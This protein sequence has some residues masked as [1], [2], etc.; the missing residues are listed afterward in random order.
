MLGSRVVGVNLLASQAGQVAS[1][2]ATSHRNLCSMLTFCPLPPP[3][4]TLHSPDLALYFLQLCPSPLDSCLAPPALL[5]TTQIP[6][7]IPASHT[8]STIPC[9]AAQISPP[10]PCSTLLRSC[11]APLLPCLTSLSPQFCAPALAHRTTLS[12]NRASH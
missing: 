7:H 4:L 12:A 1:S 2:W 5:G 11:L 8:P 10:W 9:C 3:S 6:T